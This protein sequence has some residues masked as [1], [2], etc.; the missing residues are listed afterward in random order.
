[1]PKLYVVGTGKD[2]C[3]H[4]AEY[5]FSDRIQANRCCNWLDNNGHTTTTVWEVTRFVNSDEFVKWYQS[6]DVATIK[7]DGTEI[8]LTKDE[9]KG[10]LK[11][12]ED[13]N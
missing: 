5:L 4:D 13:K 3:N 8:T 2:H 12:I 9:L 7:K 10:M 1:M 11:Q 6:K